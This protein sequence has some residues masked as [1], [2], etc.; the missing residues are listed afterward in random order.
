MKKSQIST[1]IDLINQIVGDPQE[2]EDTWIL[3]DQNETMVNQINRIWKR[4]YGGGNPPIVSDGKGVRGKSVSPKYPVDFF[5]K[6]FSNQYFGIIWPP[7]CHSTGLLSLTRSPS[8][9]I[10]FEKNDMKLPSD[11]WISRVD[12][13]QELF[14]NG[15]SDVI[16]PRFTSLKICAPQTTIYQLFSTITSIVSADIDNEVADTLFFEKIY[17]Q[18]DPTVQWNEIQ[19]LQIETSL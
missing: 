17:L 15:L 11:H 8:D 1:S 13:V 3:G 9:Y 4:R 18:T 5:D 16:L 10:L 12:C 14:K 2:Y 19:M 7:C 6:K